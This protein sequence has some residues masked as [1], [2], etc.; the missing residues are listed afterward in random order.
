DGNHAVKIAPS[1][2]TNGEYDYRIAI[3]AYSKNDAVSAKKAIFRFYR[4]DGTEISGTEKTVESTN[5]NFTLDFN[6]GKLGIT[7]GAYMTVQFVDQKG[8]AYYE[9]EMGFYFA[10]ALGLMSF[11][12]SFNFGGAEKVM[13]IIC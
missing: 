10:Q 6:P 7:T 9:H 8:V 1:G 3:Q 13:D 2:M 5:Q 12:S 11:I 4:K